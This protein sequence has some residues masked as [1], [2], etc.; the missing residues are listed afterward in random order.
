MLKQSNPQRIEALKRRAEKLSILLK[1]NRIPKDE[2][3][4]RIGE[5]E[6]LRWAIPVLEQHT[7]DSLA[8]QQEIE[9]QNAAARG[10]SER[11]A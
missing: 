2:F 4:E 3:R 5:L 6:A 10:A 8:R 7:T 11:G 9:R 1:A